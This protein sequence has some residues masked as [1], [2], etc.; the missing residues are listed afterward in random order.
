MFINTVNGSQ[1]GIFCPMRT[2]SYNAWKQAKKKGLMS[3]IIGAN[4]LG[5]LVPLTMKQAKK[6]GLMS[7]ILSCRV[8]KHVELPHHELASCTV[9]CKPIELLPPH[10][11]VPCLLARVK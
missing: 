4:V 7:W 5:K 11:S 9:N 6:E 2:P 1:Y 3:R 8:G 10:G